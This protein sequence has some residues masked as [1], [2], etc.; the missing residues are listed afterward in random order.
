MPL[1]CVSV[2]LHAADVQI[3]I[4]TQNHK[5][6]ILLVRVKICETRRTLV[7]ILILISVIRGAFELQKYNM[8]ISTDA[9]A[10]STWPVRWRFFGGALLLLEDSSA[11]GFLVFAG[12]LGCCCIFDSF[13]FEFLGSFIIGGLLL[14]F[15]LLGSDFRL[16]RSDSF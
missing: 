13:C 12:F 5:S 10:S 9:D 4:S 8:S 6:I 15:G 2:D 7:F 3:F 1:E 16:V 11:A 14:L